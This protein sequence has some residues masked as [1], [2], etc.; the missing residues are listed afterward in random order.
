MRTVFKSLGDI[1]GYYQYIKFSLE[2]IPAMLPERN[3]DF[4]YKPNARLS[5]MKKEEKLCFVGD[6]ESFIKHYYRASGS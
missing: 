5:Q 3:K 6:I 4:S 1:M 2:T